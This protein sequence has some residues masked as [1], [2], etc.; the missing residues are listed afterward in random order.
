MLK[1]TI[2][3]VSHGA[4]NSES[5]TVGVLNYFEGHHPAVMSFSFLLYLAK[6][7]PELVEYKLGAFSDPV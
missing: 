4:E 7:L 2:L 1:N 6:L 3:F 5:F